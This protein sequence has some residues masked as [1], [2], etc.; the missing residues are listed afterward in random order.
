MMLEPAFL[1][2]VLSCH[3]KERK[4]SEDKWA[5]CFRDKDRMWVRV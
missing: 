2:Y 5:V 1:V 3:T 4:C